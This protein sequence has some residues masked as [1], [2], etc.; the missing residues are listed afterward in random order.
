MRSGSPGLSFGHNLR[1]IFN[2]APP[3]M[4][5]T[6]PRRISLLVAALLILPTY[7]RA[8]G[9]TLPKGRLWVK[10]AVY[11][12]RTSQRFCT[13]ENAAQPLYRQAGCLHAGD[14]APFDPVTLG[15]VEA[16][17]IFTD[18]AYGLTDGLEIGVKLPFYAVRFT[19]LSN[20]ARPGTTTLGDL[21]LY[22]RYRLLNGPVVATLRAAVK[23]PTGAFTI[24][25]EVVNVSEGQWDFEL[26]GE[27]GKSFWPLPI[28]V[29]A[30]AGYRLRT[31]NGHFDHSVADEISALA[32]AGLNFSARFSAR[33]TAD[34]LYSGQPRARAFDTRLR[35]RRELL[36]VAPAIAYA[37]RS[38][39][40]LEGSVR[41][42]VRGQ[43]FPAGPQFIVAL[44]YSTS[45]W[46]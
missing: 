5:E 38:G 10:S 8:G 13:E 6:K 9:W 29:S 1:S 27:V 26:F 40:W 19:N 46:R 7:L 28:W 33:V 35:I 30:E 16:L 3:I 12:Q 41:F 15:E 34:W 45:L 11:Y 37:L 24:D 2:K 39:L 22:V 31:N 4:Y 36:T 25:A 42:P 17:A 20:P 23:S 44:S 14:S 43:D 21:R 32:E 18:I